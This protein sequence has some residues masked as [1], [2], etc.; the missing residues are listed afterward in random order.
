MYIIIILSSKIDLT[1]AVF[2]GVQ[3]MAGLLKLVIFSSSH[4]H[5]RDC[6]LKTDSGRIFPCLTGE[7]N[8]REQ[9]GTRRS[10]NRAV[11]AWLVKLN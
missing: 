4:E 2:F 6:A 5:V 10:S 1:C 8:L 7:S 11:F 9:R 3:T